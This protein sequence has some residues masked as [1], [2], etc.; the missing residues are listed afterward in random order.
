MRFTVEYLDRVNFNNVIIRGFEKVERETQEYSLPID[1][2]TFFMLSHLAFYHQTYD[3]FFI[4]QLTYAFYQKVIAK[5]IR[6]IDLPKKLDLT[7]TEQLRPFVAKGLTAAAL[8]VAEQVYEMRSRNTSDIRFGKVFPIYAEVFG[9]AAVKARGEVVMEL[10]GASGENAILLAFAGASKVYMNDINTSELEIFKSVKKN[11]PKQIQAK[12]ELLPGDCLEVLAQRKALD[13]RIGLVLC[14]NL[15]HFFDDSQQMDFFLSLKATMKVGGLAI[16]TANHYG[17]ELPINE[18]NEKRFTT[19]R[20]FRVLVYDYA[21]SDSPIAILSDCTLPYTGKSIPLTLQSSYLY[22]REDSG[23]K[24]KYTPNVFDE[25]K[26][27][28]IIREA[29]KKDVENNWSDKISQVRN[30][31][32]RIGITHTRAYTK[33]NLSKLVQHYGF[34]VE[35]IF[36]VDSA[37]HL[38]SENPSSQI[39]ICITR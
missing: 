32:V 21:L 29:I 23:Q 24:W 2:T 26:V 35:A 13:E 20:R 8:K 31:S 10:A 4:N 17:F 22:K 15:I 11:L 33:E 16:L 34:A 1:R 18:V 5:G 25:L 28:N 38:S 7:N 6:L 9:Y 30:G 39:G 36:F 37:G 14:R 3:L 27:P 19:F 12:L